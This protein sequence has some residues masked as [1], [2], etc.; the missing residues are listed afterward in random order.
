MVHLRKLIIFKNNHHKT[1]GLYMFSGQ[2]KQKNRVLHG[3][4]KVG[5]LYFIS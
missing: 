5:T 3:I 4:G 1:K 2:L